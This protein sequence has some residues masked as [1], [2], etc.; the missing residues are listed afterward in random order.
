MVR[1]IT[2]II[3]FFAVAAGAVAQEALVG[4][5]G[6]ARPGG[7][8]VTLPSADASACAALCARDGLCMAWT[9]RVEP[10]CELKAVIPSPIA[11]PG[12][13]SGLSARA[14]DFARH[15]AIAGAETTVDAPTP[16]QQPRAEYAQ[17][18]GDFAL[19]GGLTDAESPLRPRFSGSP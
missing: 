13:T 18:A 15:L 4:A 3:A 14:P 9:Q 5:R 7:A 10:V 19:L 1:T 17:P 11:A 12:V 8:Y 16:A 6:V 2:F